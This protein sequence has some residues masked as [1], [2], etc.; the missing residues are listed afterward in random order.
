MGYDDLFRDRVAARLSQLEIN[1]FEAARRA[2]LER[3]FVN[4]ILIRRKK[5]VRGTN[6][7]KLAAGLDCDVDFLIGRNDTPRAIAADPAQGVPLVGVCEAGVWRHVSAPPTL[8]TI[9][10]IERD[11]RFPDVPQQAFE[12]RGSTGADL[13]IPDGSIVV[14]LDLNRWADTNPEVGRFPCVIRRTRAEAG[15]VE[16]SIGAAAFRPAG[17]SI[18]T[19]GGAALADAEVL[20]VICVSLRFFL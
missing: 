12:V 18:M 14:A 11:L 13:G 4:D 16:T 8:P 10:A 17:L 15:E 5:S 9:A 20:G 1:P 19:A 3:S 2:G 6:L 7:E